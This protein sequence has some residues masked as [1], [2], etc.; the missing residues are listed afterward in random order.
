M[1]KTRNIEKFDNI[2]KV[3][4]D[5][6]KNLVEYKTNLIEK[7]NEINNYYQGKDAEKI[8]TKF[9]SAVNLLDESV[10]NINSYI[11]YLNNLSNNDKST[12]E[13]FLKK[14]KSLKNEKI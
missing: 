10:D 11:D 8:I 1:Q 9:L 2:V 7:I 3:T 4:T 13:Y 14:M 12:I 6:N 5:I